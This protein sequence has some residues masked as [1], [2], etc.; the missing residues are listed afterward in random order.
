MAVVLFAFMVTSCG[1]NCY[2][3][4]V[5]EQDTIQC[6]NN[7]EQVGDFSW[8]VNI[9]DTTCVLVELQSDSLNV[10]NVYVTPGIEVEFDT[11]GFGVRGHRYGYAEFF[12][13]IRL[14]E[15]NLIQE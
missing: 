2:N 14:D 11:T 6:P 13:T 8:H 7:I 10:L 3:A 4:P 12:D 1:N 5:E 15:T 9:D